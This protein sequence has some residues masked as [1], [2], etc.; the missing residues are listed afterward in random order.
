MP[1]SHIITIH[2]VS[3]NQT[4]IHEQAGKVDLLGIAVEYGHATPGETITI[5][6]IDGVPPQKP[7]A[8]AWIPS[9]NIYATQLTNGDWTLIPA[10]R[11]RSNVS[12][13][14]TSR[15]TGITQPRLSEFEVGGRLMSQATARTAIALADY[16]G[17]TVQ[18][19]VE[20]SR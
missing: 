8:A 3:D 10:L 20:F 15:A 1:K 5:T 13:V 2:R 9:H 17:V 7:L 4:L 18:D 14:D 19:I 16:L 6:L 11:R 12:Q